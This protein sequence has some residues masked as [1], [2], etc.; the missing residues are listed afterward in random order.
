VIEE[1]KMMFKINI[2]LKISGRLVC[3]VFCFA[4]QVFG[5][6]ETACLAGRTGFN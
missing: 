6:A 4:K 3:Q 1:N 5:K 2:I